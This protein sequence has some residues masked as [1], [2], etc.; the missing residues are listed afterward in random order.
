MG[1]VVNTNVASLFAQRS[2]NNTNSS[3]NVALQRLSSGLR[4]NGA[5]DDAAGL[6]LATRFS[7]QISGLE[8]ANRN[9]NDGISMLQTAEGALNEVTNGLQRIRELAVQSANG[10]VTTADRANLQAEVLSVQNEIIRISDST[11]FGNRTVIGNT[12]STKIMVG[13]RSASANNLISVSTVNIDSTGT[14]GIGTALSTNTKVSSVANALSAVSIIDTA[15]DR[16]SNLRAK[17]GAAQ[18]RLEIAARNNANVV[19]NQSAAKSRIL[20]ADFARESANLTRSQILQQAGVA[21]LA[22]ANALPQ[23]ALSL[24]G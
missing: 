22:Q 17:Y 19:E 16:I 11:R 4:I 8:Q 10:T 15:L 12:S 3:L 13:F 1:Q 9:A 6:A 23:T 18:N 24:L 20:D 21:M 5:R 14:Y 7:A 2:L